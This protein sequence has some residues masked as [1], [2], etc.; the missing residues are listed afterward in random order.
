MGADR[1]RAARAQGR[2]QLCAAHVARLAGHGDGRDRYDAEPSR[3][4]PRTLRRACR[5]AA[6]TD[7]AGNGRVSAA[8]SEKTAGNQIATFKNPFLPSSEWGWAIDPMGLRISLNEIYDMY[9]L[10]MMIV[11]NGFGAVDQFDED[12]NIIDDYRIDYMKR[13]IKAMKD[14]IDIDGVELLGYTAWGCIDLV[15]AGT[16][17]M[18]KRYGLVYVDMDDAGKG[19]LKRYKK[20]SFDWY[21]KVI[22]T[23]GEEL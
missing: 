23:N 21:R 22:E 20:K 19:T 7:S 14:A 18:K 5:R 3:V 9:Q 17:E 1:K 15:S 11:E 10:P 13:H 8:F 6:G 2:R 16:G 12:G 4:F